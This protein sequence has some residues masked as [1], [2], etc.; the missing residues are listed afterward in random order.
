MLLIELGQHLCVSLRVTNRACLVISSY[1]LLDGT[2]QFKPQQ[3]SE[4]GKRLL[5]ASYS[6]ER[7]Y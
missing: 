6:R 1:C 5:R 2:S 3:S 4:L 7:S